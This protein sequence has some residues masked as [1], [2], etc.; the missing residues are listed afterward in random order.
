MTENRYSYIKPLLIHLFLGGLIFLLPFI[1][2]IYSILIFGFGLY[3]ISKKK[4]QNNEALIFSAYVVG[5]EVLLRM[6]DG[7]HFNEYAKYSIIIFML[8][9]I[10]YQGV[11]REA[12][13]YFIFILFLFPGVLYGVYSLSF[14][15]NIRKAIAFNISGPVCLGISAIYC[16]NRVVTY[17][18]MR[19]II[20]AFSLPIASIIVY[21]LLY[22]PSI[23]DVVTSTQ[24][25]FETSGGFGPN[26]MST[27]LGLGMFVYFAIFYLFLE[28]RTEKI[29][30]LA[31]TTIAAFRG[32]M[33]FSRGGMYTGLLMIVSLVFVTFFFVN[34][35]VKA[36]IVVMA[37]CLV[38]AGM[39][40]W[41]Y[42]T[43]Q[44]GG[45]IDKR[46]ANQDA[47]GREKSSALTGREQLIESEFK[48]FFDNPI[49]GVGV[50]RNK[51]Y[52]EEMT[53]IK[54]AS[55]NEISRML[56]EHG[57]LGVICL[58]IL[59]ITPFLVYINNRQ[60]VFMLCFFLFWLLTINHAAMRLSAPAFIYGL[61]LLKLKIVDEATVHRE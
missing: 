60:H 42:S 19:N 15:A 36:G 33:T 47:R 52:R 3:V 56:A 38:L 39:G 32:L 23:K 45:L 51:E 13:V 46:Y 22:N 12:F 59:F 35:K 28:S 54:A 31:M 9:G 4:N 34:K 24:S 14:E 27:V 41:V 48:M 8:Y 20:Y 29:A 57:V 49:T 53:G 61:S 5:V 17:S 6:T 18:Q 11:R 10:F 25:N 1:T 2:K 21:L 40:I 16:I 44:T 50:G 26:Q 30:V 7:M 43:I 58:L 55:H 37:M